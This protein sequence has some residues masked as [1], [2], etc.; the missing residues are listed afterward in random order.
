[1]L[2]DFFFSFFAEG[3]VLNVFFVTGFILGHALVGLFLLFIAFMCHAARLVPD[4]VVAAFRSLLLF[5]NLFIENV[6]AGSIGLNLG[7][8]VIKSAQ[9]RD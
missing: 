6:I 1:V 9:Y 7:S 2:L 4:R 5:F 3:M 8:Q